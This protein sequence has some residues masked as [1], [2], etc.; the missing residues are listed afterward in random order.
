MKSLRKIL[1]VLVATAMVAGMGAIAFAG[2]GSI[3]ITSNQSGKVNGRQFT[4]Y[5]ILDATYASGTSGVTTIAYSIPPQLLPFYQSYFPVSDY[6]GSAQ[7]QRGESYEKYVIDTISKFSADEVQNFITAFA[8]RYTSLLSGTYVATKAA[9]SGDDTL[10]F[11]NLSSGYY[12]IVDNNGNPLSALM[13]DTVLNEDVEI[14][15]KANKETPDKSILGP[16]GPIEVK[17]A[18]GNRV[19]FLNDDNELSAG[20]TVNYV[21]REHVPNYAGYEYFYYILNDVL[22]KGLTFLPESVRIEIDL[23]GDSIFGEASAS[24]ILKNDRP[25]SGT[26]QVLA[27]GTSIT[28]SEVLTQGSDYYLY[29][30]KSGDDTHIRIAFDDIMDFPVDTPIRVYYSAN[31]NKDAITGINSNTNEAFLQYSDRHNS[32]TSGTKRHDGP[33]G[34]PASGTEGILDEGPR[35]WTD[36]YTTEIDVIK[37]DGS[38]ALAGAQFTLVGNSTQYV[39]KNQVV[40]TVNPSGSYWMTKSGTYTTQAPTSGT[41]MDPAPSGSSAGYVLYQPGDTEVDKDKWVTMPNGQIYIPYIASLHNGRDLYI[42]TIGTEDKYAS[43]VVKY[44]SGVSTTYEGKSVPVK[45]I[46]GG[47]GS[48]SN[49]FVFDQLGAGTYTLSET[50]VP[51][52]YNKAADITFTINWEP[53]SGTAAGRSGTCNW[54][55][56]DAT[57]AGS[58]VTFTS[59]TAE[60]LGTFSVTVVNNKGVELPSTGGIGTTIFYAGGAILVLL[61]GILLVSKRRFA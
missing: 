59:G 61:A 55:I 32:G 39:V 38:K 27:S 21:V 3:T 47:S 25:K 46:L 11:D 45:M 43:T 8:D 26:D 54:W 44:S 13:L 16:S 41:K 40:Y 7:Q 14:V 52:G 9:G 36:T 15:L 19:G 12:V 6:S 10:T 51:E 22:S 20:S 4:A 57:Q 28:R 35:D 33:S 50:K 53:N 60:K 23:D 49:I 29:Y 1:A 48:G 58:T 42:L 31:L 37:T 2:V 24:A 56:T 30:E 18:S 17:D 34:V 5:R